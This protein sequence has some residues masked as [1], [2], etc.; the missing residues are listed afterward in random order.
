MARNWYKMDFG[1]WRDEK[2]RYLIAIASESDAFRYFKLVALAYE[3]G[4]PRGVIDLN[5]PMVKVTVLDE[6]RM[7]FQELDELVKLCVSCGLFSDTYEVFGKITSERMVAAGQEIDAAIESARLAGKA[8]AEK[9]REK[10]REKA[11]KSKR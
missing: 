9:R 1:F 7:T 5:D 3:Y 8:S 4:K 10:A 2:V 11:R 6:M